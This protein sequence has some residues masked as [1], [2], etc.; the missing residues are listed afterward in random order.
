MVCTVYAVVAGNTLTAVCSGRHV[1]VRLRCIDSRKI[2]RAAVHDPP[3]LYLSPQEFSRSV[4][5]VSGKGAHWA[6][7]LIPTVGRGCSRVVRPAGWSDRV[8]AGG[9][10]R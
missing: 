1:K 3:G 2:E 10:W 9:E 4:V 5:R 7:G 6:H 8:F